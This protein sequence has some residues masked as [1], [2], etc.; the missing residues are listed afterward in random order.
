MF[1]RVLPNDLGRWPAAT[2]TNIPLSLFV[3]SRYKVAVQTGRAHRWTSHTGNSQLPRLF[4]EN[5]LYT[6][7]R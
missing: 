3:S 7:A 5:I 1:M 2:A 6:H 4:P